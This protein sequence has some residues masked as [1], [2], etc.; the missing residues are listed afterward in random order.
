[1]RA[2]HMPDDNVRA[3]R[4][5]LAEV[6]LDA[7][8]GAPLAP[9]LPAGLTIKRCIDI[10][11]AASLLVTLSPLLA[12]V[13]A[14]IRLTS[15]GPVFFHQQRYGLG[16]HRFTI[17]KFRTMYAHDT[18]TSGI[19]QTRSDDPRVTPLGRFLRRTNLDELPQL[20]NVVCGDMSLVGPRPHVPGMRAGGVL[21]ET[22]VPY[23]FTR[24]R[25][26]PGITGLAQINEMRGS[27][28]DPKFAKA[29]IDYDNAYIDHWSLALDFRIFWTTL[30]TEILRGTGN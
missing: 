3:T 2:L 1:M 27:T 5:R 21:Y 6:G 28:S 11:G 29:R 9:V 10:V 13:A 22:L 17:L 12:L 25:M 20:I 15:P 16:S 8:A 4:Q 18:D 19:N 7:G 24:H 14:A 23:Y 26:R 30:K